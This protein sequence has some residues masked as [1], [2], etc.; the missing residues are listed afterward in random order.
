MCAGLFLLPP[1]GSCFLECICTQHLCRCCGTEFTRSLSSR[2][3]KDHLLFLCL[4][5][6]LMLWEIELDWSSS[7]FKPSMQPLSRMGEAGPHRTNPSTGAFILLPFFFLLKAA[8]TCSTRQPVWSRHLRV[9]QSQMLP[10][11][12]E[13]HRG[14]RRH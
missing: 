4:Q 1:R 6:N 2:E 13:D 5:S 7:R 11:G 8:D 9:A 14:P 3:Q 12:P 10:T